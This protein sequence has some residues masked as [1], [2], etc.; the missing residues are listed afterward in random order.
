ML[1]DAIPHLDFKGIQ[2]DFGS[3]T[4]HAVKGHY[5]FVQFAD[6]LSLPYLHLPTGFSTGEWDECLDNWLTSYLLQQCTVMSTN[7]RQKPKRLHIT[8]KQPGKLDRWLA[9]GHFVSQKRAL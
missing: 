2:Y 8:D 9:N 7:R 5:V 6:V 4:F 1:I 3:I